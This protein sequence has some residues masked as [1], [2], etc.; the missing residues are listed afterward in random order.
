MTPYESYVTYLALK[1][2]F[3]TDSYDFLQYNG[4][5]RA[6]KDSFE[7]RRDKY[8]FSK[9]AKKEDPKH[10]LIAN[11]L[12]DPNIWI[13]TLVDDPIHDKIYTEWKKRS[14]S[15]MYIFK[16]EI[17]SLDDDLDGILRTSGDYPKLFAGYLLDLVCPETMIILDASLRFMPYWKKNID[18]TII[19]PDHYRKLQK[20]KPFVRF[21]KDK[22]K[23]IMQ[24]RWMNEN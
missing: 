8:F 3:T 22:T 24:E 7:S 4:K 23:K 6:S 1:R 15:L 5:I 9:L 2:H 13:G 10:F 12:K 20:Y 17:Y 11:F 14:Q 16:Q 21:D 19:F 18:D